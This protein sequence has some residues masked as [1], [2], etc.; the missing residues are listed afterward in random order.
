MEALTQGK[1]L[2]PMLKLKYFWRRLTWEEGL[3]S[4]FPKLARY[5][6]LYP[7]LYIVRALKVLVYRRKNLN[8]E[9]KAVRRIHNDAD[10]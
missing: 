1:Q 5:K 6:L 4:D 8:N 10:K 2:S 9:I 3:Y 7:V